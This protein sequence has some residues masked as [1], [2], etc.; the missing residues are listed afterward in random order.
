[1][2]NCHCDN[3]WAKRWEWRETDCFELNLFATEKLLAQITQCNGEPESGKRPTR[4]N[5]YLARRILILLFA[6]VCS[7]D[8]GQKICSEFTLRPS[9]LRFFP[10]PF[11]LDQFWLLSKLRLFLINFAVGKLIRDNHM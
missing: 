9:I 6:D 11:F 4:L 5:V 2:G 8:A 7:G 3:L 10:G 1:M